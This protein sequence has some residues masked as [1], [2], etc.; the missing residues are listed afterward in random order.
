[1]R[2]LILGLSVWA[3]LWRRCRSVPC[4]D[5]GSVALCFLLEL[6]FADVSAGGGRMLPPISVVDSL[7]PLPGLRLFHACRPTA[8]VVGCNLSPL[9]GCD[10][11]LLTDPRFGLRPR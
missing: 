9:R 1:M 7:T 3:L 2:I 4:E 11:A 5:T 10:L 8:C 6:N